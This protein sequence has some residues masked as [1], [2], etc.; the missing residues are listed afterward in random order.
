MHREYYE[1]IFKF[2]IHRNQKSTQG[3]IHNSLAAC[4]WISPLLLDFT[5]KNAVNGRRIPLPVRSTGR[6][7]Q[8]GAGGPAPTVC[9]LQPVFCTVLSPEPASG[10]TITRVPLWLS[11][12]RGL[13]SALLV[14]P[15]HP[16]PGSSH[17]PSPHRLSLLWA[18]PRTRS[19]PMSRA[20]GHRM[21]GSP[22][23]WDQARPLPPTTVTP[24]QG[25][26]ATQ[27]HVQ[28]LPGP[29]KSFLWCHP[30]EQP[31]FA[32]AAPAEPAAATQPPGF[33]SPGWGRGSR[34]PRGRG[35]GEEGGRGGWQWG[36]DA[37]P[38]Y[39][40]TQPGTGH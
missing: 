31:F 25:G 3:E 23:P 29:A 9:P 26:Q 32:A 34:C 33:A 21:D 19:T 36:S 35:A 12:R 4:R 2:F 27:S 28:P 30:W 39:S 38:R 7:L 16:H 37:P 11:V 15:G 13:S 24:K 17:L 22:H 6:S 14:P 20:V 5:S 1:K 10:S 18:L 40:C 8:P